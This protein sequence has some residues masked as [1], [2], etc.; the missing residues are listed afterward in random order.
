MLIFKI[1]VTRANQQYF[2]PLNQAPLPPSLT[3]LP[4][5]SAQTC[6]NYRALPSTTI[7]QTGQHYSH[8]LEHTG[9]QHLVSAT[10]SLLTA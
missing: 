1:I 5:S 10:Y 8:N 7:W 6:N 3:I 2:L 9:I 4:P